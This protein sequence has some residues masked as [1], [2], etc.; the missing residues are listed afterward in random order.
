MG[1]FH[2]I[3]GGIESIQLDIVGF[4]AVLGEGSVLINAQVAAL[5]Q[6]TYLPRFMPAPQALIQPS[7]A[8]KLKSHNGYTTAVRSGNVRDYINHIGHILVNSEHY[9]AY[10]VRC[11]E[12]KRKHEPGA[13]DDSHSLEAKKH[14]STKNESI[15][16][17]AYGPLW[18]VA[19]TGCSLSIITFAFAIRERDGMALLSIIL[20]SFLSSL[21]GIA[22]KWKLQLPK[23]LNK[24]QFTPPGDVVI[25][26]AKGSFLIVQCTED[27]ARELFFAPE[28]IE[29]L[30]QE[31]WEYRLISLVGTIT[32]MFGVIFLG[33]ASVYLQLGIAG[34][35]IIMNVLYWIVAALPSRL[36][37]DV[38]CFVVEDQVIA[39]CD[40]ELP[41]ARHGRKYIDYNKT[42]TTALWKAIV[43]TKETEWA[44]RS[45][46]VP[47]HPAW[48]EWLKLAKVKAREAGT[49]EEKVGNKT[50]KV[51]DLP[52]WNSQLALSTCF[53]KAA[54]IAAKLEQEE[55][56]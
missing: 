50:I 49:R 26:Y 43:V 18:F 36:H 53:E 42:F 21:V 6:V 37:W 47:S 13:H 24:N 38:S 51:W 19:V 12:I 56:V 11:V 40:S 30:I 17:K 31:A 25:R 39:P 2:W 3:K 9:P 35:Y 44:V 20:L 32:L 8:H 45:S 16:S 28:D 7:R 54:E 15:T 1:Y 46:A 29:Y 27:V 4:L 33:N 5:S 22:N 52:E 34:S 55:Q 41:E 48:T 23:R 14:N 10:S